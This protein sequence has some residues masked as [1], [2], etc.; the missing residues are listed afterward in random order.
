MNAMSSCYD[1]LKIVDK[2][3]KNI[4]FEN[5]NV[6]RYKSTTTATHIIRT[7]QID[8]PWG[9]IFFRG[10]TSFLKITNCDSQYK[11]FKLKR[12]NETKKIKVWFQNRLNV[13]NFPQRFCKN[14]FVICS[15]SNIFR[16]GRIVIFCQFVEFVLEHL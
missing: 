12:S 4:I 14:K 10:N 3:S 7:N 16:F 13:W 5:T 15:S 2:F 11:I 8:M 1:F 6:W 9:L